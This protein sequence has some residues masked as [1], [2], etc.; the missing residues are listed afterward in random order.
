MC[1]T[2]K[3]IVFERC[4]LQTKGRTGV[5]WMFL[6]AFR[7][8]VPS[9]C[10]GLAPNTVGSSA[11]A[12]AEA[13]ASPDI[14]QHVEH[15]AAAASRT[16]LRAMASTATTCEAGEPMSSGYLS[17][18]ASS[19]VCIFSRTS[20]LTQHTPADSGETVPSSSSAIMPLTA[21]AMTHA[22]SSALSCSASSGARR[23]CALNCCSSAPAARSSPAAASLRSRAI[24]SSFSRCTHKYAT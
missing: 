3:S 1:A 20:W 8:S 21:R 6:T 15:G 4:V 11:T 19:S 14:E 24:L 2:D 22:A 10:D 16:E 18:T 9:R 7:K 5:L 17:S 12:S 13:Q 23:S